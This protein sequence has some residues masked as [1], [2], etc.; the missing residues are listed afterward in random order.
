M[1]HAGPHIPAVILAGRTVSHDD[2]LAE[3]AQGRP[4]ALI[5]LAGRPMVSYV[6]DALAGSKFVPAITVVGLE[7]LPGESFAVPVDFLPDAHDLLENAETG[8]RHAATLC[9]AA[10]G[11]LISSSDVPLVTSAMIDTQIGEF[12]HT[13]HDF[14][15][16]AIN[17]SVMEARF[18]GSRRSYV[19]LREGDFAGGDI[20]MLHPSLVMQDRALWERLSDA[21]K[22]VL[23]QAR[24]IGLWTALLLITRRLSLA[25]AERRV[26]KA[27]HIH[28]R[29]VPCPFAEIGMDVDKPFQLDIVRAEIEARVATPTDHAPS[30]N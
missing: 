19:H 23:K 27:L 22:S 26:S 4:K 20:S 9:P 16:S 28:G 12:L 24:L 10:R 15:Y 25:A 30:P 11:V 1:T 2:P 18:P 6:I 13:E 14:Y 29:V 17:R 5:P 3:H 21:R 8:L 7:G